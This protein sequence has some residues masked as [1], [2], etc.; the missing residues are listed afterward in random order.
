MRHTLYSLSL[1]LEEIIKLENLFYMIDSSADKV[2]DAFLIPRKDIEFYMFYVS[3]K[4]FYANVVANRITLEPEDTAAMWSR[5]K[6]LSMS[7]HL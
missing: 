1:F 5:N 7:P 6:L 4:V 2:E 3:W